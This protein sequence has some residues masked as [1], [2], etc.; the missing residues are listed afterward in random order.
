MKR[1]I[2]CF[3]CLYCKVSVKSTA[4]CRLCFCAES[5]K[6]AKHKEPYWFTKKVCEKFNDMGRERLPKNQKKPDKK[7]E[8]ENKRWRLITWRY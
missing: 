1:I 4:N 3:D 5:L 7:L 2:T 6:K 8:G